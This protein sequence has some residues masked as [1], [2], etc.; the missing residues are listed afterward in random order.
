MKIR[1][2][3]RIK[4]KKRVLLVPLDWGLG[5]ATRCI[6]LIRLLIKQQVEVFVAGE[7]KIIALLEKELPEIV[8]LPLKG[9]RVSYSKH[10]NNLLIKLLFQLPK[11]LNAIRMEQKWLQCVILEHQIDAVISDNRFG[12]YN[13]N[14]PSVFITHQLSIQTGNKWLNRVA[15]KINYS[16]INKFND[17]WV[18]DLAGSINLAEELSHPAIL[19]VTP[20]SYLGIL[21][22]CTKVQVKKNIDLL[23]LVSG[24]EPQRTIFETIFL[25]ELKDTTLSVVLLRGLPGEQKTISIENKKVTVFNHLSSKELNQLMQEA[26]LVIARSGYSSIMDLVSLHQKAILVP[27]PGQT[28]QEYL[29]RILMKKGLFYSARQENFSLKSVLEK[30]KGFKFNEQVLNPEFDEALLIKWLDK[31]KSTV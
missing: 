14:I 3:N 12:L 9:Y 22:R 28:E 24:P 4:E 15:Q 13:N 20:V 18:P 6:P 16:Y 17:C 30:V 19:P 7:G 10:R 29:A 11:V 23:I 26:E 25:N 2:I 8:I 27:T 21:S 5:H 1:K 31:I